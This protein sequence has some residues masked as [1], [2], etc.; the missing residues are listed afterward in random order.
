MQ[1]SSELAESSSVSQSERIDTDSIDPADRGLL[2]PNMSK[3]LSSI[4]L[5]DE[6]AQLKQQ[7]EYLKK[8]LRNKED[9]MYQLEEELASL[10]SK[11]KNLLIDHEKRM[12]ELEAE[13]DGKLAKLREE[14]NRQK[15]E[16]RDLENSIEDNQVESQNYKTKYELQ[17][18]NLELVT[19]Q[20]EAS[21][22]DHQEVVRERDETRRELEEARVNI[23]QL[24]SSYSDKQQELV[25]LSEQAVRLQNI[26][27]K[28]VYEKSVL[29]AKA[30]NHDTL[31][32]KLEVLTKFYENVK[33]LYANA[34]DRNIDLSDEIEKLKKQLFA[35]MVDESDR[36]KDYY[37]MKHKM[38]HFDEEMEL[39]M[40]IITSLEQD[41]AEAR[42]LQSRYKEEIAKLQDVAAQAIKKQER[43]QNKFEGELISQEVL[44]IA[45]EREF[46]IIGK[47]IGSFAQ[48]NIEA[49][50]KWDIYIQRKD[51]NIKH[52]KALT[53]Q[54]E[55]IQENSTRSELEMIHNLKEYFDI[56]FDDES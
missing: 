4:E 23:Q 32:R 10:S 49:M 7:V 11:Y 14:L 1:S 42:K 33:S 31:Q 43:L 26:L 37:T 21:R 54:I 25:E 15:Q 35:K 22:T 29:Y 9:E 38:N 5:E 16:Y 17:A 48:Q 27:S 34:S 36:S 46:A 40:E 8:T 55:R 30:Q 13:S 18:K 41:L 47:V 53:R 51:A 6:N 28:Q 52:L 45:I 19:Q 50:Q 56:E 2:Y 39:K 3:L 24:E 20:R 44:K 12:Y